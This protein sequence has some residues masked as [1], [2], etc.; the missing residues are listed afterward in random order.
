MFQS[1]LDGIKVN[2]GC[3][4]DEWKRH[5]CDLLIYTG[6]IDEY[7]NYCYGWLEY[8]SLKIQF[9][10]APKRKNIFQLNECN[11]KQS[12]RSI[13]HSHWHRQNVKETVISKEYPMEHNDSNTPFYP[14]PFGNNPLKYKKYKG[15]A[16]REKK[17][18]FCW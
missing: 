4:K 8:R 15:L 10:T 3:N 14:K 2:L 5:N 17:D 12:T 11:K 16:M 18:D 6:K 9:E 7:F 1:M 13:D